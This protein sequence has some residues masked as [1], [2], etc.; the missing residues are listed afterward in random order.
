MGLWYGSLELAAYVVKYFKGDSAFEIN[1]SNKIN[2]Y[3]YRDVILVSTMSSFSLLLIRP[4]L[5]YAF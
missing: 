2:D 3:P 4:T 5:R 1:Q